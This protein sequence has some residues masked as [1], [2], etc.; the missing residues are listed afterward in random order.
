MIRIGIVGLGFM[1][2]VHFYGAKRIR[3]GKVVAIATRNPRKLAGDW[4]MIQGNFGPRGSSSEDLRGVEIC[5]DINQLLKNP[6]IDLVDICLP[7]DQHVQ[8]TIDALRAGKQVLVEKP[9][10]L[11][12]ADAGRMVDAAHKSGKHLLVAQVLPF[13]PEYSFALAAVRSGQYGKLIG[14]H[15]KRVIA[16]PNWSQ[17]GER[18]EKTGGPAIDLH[19]HDTHFIALICG[20]PNA[21]YARGSVV[22]DYV[23]YLATH[24]LYDDPELCI[25]CSS[26]AVSQPGRAFTHGF[27]IYLERATLLYEFATLDNK[28]HLLTPLTVLTETGDVERPELGSGDP[29]D[30]F[31]N[32]IQHAVN[33]IGATVDP[34]ELSGELARDALV[35]CRKEEESVKTGK[36]V[37]V[38]A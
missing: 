17:D 8:V 24:Y 21:V 13:F 18:L 36:P 27:E 34:A 26:G 29:I 2:M 11:D 23:R 35:L 25:T 28:P 33:V 30:A 38:G 3:N 5:S 31:A 37:C 15:F 22:G 9:I 16:Q 10:A 7:T 4:S 19:I 1:G 20:V 14:A 32:E 12:V 6:D